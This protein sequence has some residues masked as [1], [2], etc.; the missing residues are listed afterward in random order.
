MD[1]NYITEQTGNEQTLEP[2]NGQ[3]LKANKRKRIAI[4]VS[5][6]L[7]VISIAVLLGVVL[8]KIILDIII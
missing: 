6:T 4:Y 7:S 1:D 3:V 8:G 2:D 5:V